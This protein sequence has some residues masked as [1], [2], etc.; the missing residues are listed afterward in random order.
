MNN[1]IT[2]DPGTDCKSF[3]HVV[4]SF[5]LPKKVTCDNTT[6]DGL[7]TE[8]GAQ[9]NCS[10]ACSSDRQYFFPVPADGLMMFQ[11]NFY[12]PAMPDASKAW[13]TWITITLYDVD[14]NIV[15]ADH[16]V[17]ASRW[18][19]GH[20]G[21][22][23]FQNIEI[24]FSLVAVECGYFKISS[25]GTDICTHHFH[26]EDCTQL[27]EL[28]SVYN[29][30]A[31]CWGNYYG[32]AEAGFIGSDNFA[33]TN[34]I[35]LAASTKYFGVNDDKEILRLTPKALIPPYMER[36]ISMKVLKSKSIYVDGD[37][38][39]NVDNIFTPREKSTMFWPI[40]QFERPICS[41]VSGC[42]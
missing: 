14:D 24:D 16:T 21:K 5:C 15:E 36:Y 34:K 3:N 13:G 41:D 22:I 29:A 2:V 1:Y 4:T 37:L 30:K 40:I 8:C 11:T 42:N 9:W 19:V 17:F 6:I 28:E 32:I 23:P 31:D 18:V 10:R 25:G 26:K 7:F 33:Y 20:S 38:W 35:W 39:R 27:V 12:H